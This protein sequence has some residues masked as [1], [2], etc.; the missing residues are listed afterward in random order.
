[1]VSDFYQK[2]ST[3]INLNRLSLTTESQQVPS[4]FPQCLS[5]TRNPTPQPLLSLENISAKV[6]YKLR[7]K[8]GRHTLETLSLMGN[9]EIYFAINRRQ[10]PALGL[11]FTL[12]IG[13]IKG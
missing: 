2:H 11:P 1:M 5:A 7:A 6:S 13:Y 12:Y 10:S 3:S 4:R 8:G 9:K